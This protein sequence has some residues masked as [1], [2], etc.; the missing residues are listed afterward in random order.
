[1]VVNDLGVTLVG[2][3]EPSSPAN[4]VVADIKAAGG[5]AAANL[6][7]ISTMAGGEALV[8]AGG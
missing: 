4:D 2:D 7:D 3:R 6:V 1:M 5:R 8:G